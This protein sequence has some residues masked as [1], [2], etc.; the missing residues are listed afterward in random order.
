MA[1]ASKQQRVEV[2]VRLRPTNGQLQTV[3]TDQHHA[4][5]QIQ[6]QQN[7]TR[8]SNSSNNANQER[9]FNFDGVLDTT[10]S[11]QDVLDL[12][13]LNAV[14]T[15]ID[16]VNSTIFAYGQT[17]SGKT[18][19]ITG[20]TRSFEDRGLCA[21][22][23]AKLFRHA[24][25]SRLDGTGAVTIRVSYVEIYNE[26]V[27]DLLEGGAIAFGG[28]LSQQ[29]QPMSIGTDA[30]AT[31]K[32]GLQIQEKKNGETSLR[33]VRKSLVCSE[34][35]ALNVLFDGETNR[36]IAEHS[37]NQASTRSHCVLTIYIHTSYDAPDVD[38]T[39][40]TSAKLHLVDLAGSE[41]MHKTQSTG[42]TM[43]E[44]LYVNRSLSYLEQVVVALGDKTREHIPYRQSK[45]T[46]ML[47]DSLGGNCK[48][49]MIAC[50]WP[51]AEHDDQTTATLSFAKRMRRVKNAPRVN[52]AK[53]KS[54]L[55][56]KYKSEIKQLRA[57]LA[58]HD[59]MA[60]R[61]GIVYVPLTD[62]QKEE[63]RESVVRFVRDPETNSIPVVSV[64]QVNAVFH[65]FRSML[66]DGG[67]VSPRP[68]T[69]PAGGSSNSGK[70]FATA[71]KP[72]R[73]AAAW[74]SNN[75]TSTHSTAPTAPS[76]VDSK[77]NSK[78][79][80]V[81]FDEFKSGEGAEVNELLV[82]AK[83]DVKAKKKQVKR[84][85][86][87]V[88]E[89]KLQ[90]DL[91]LE[92]SR[93]VTEN[94]DKQQ[95]LQLLKQEKKQYRNRYD[96]LQEAQSELKAAQVIKDRCFKQLVC[97]FERSQRVSVDEKLPVA[98]DEKRVLSPGCPRN[99]KDGRSPTKSQ[100]SNDSCGCRSSTRSIEEDTGSNVS[101]RA[102]PLS[103]EQAFISA[104]SSALSRKSSHK[105]RSGTS[106]RK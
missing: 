94:N 98:A 78:Y 71:A 58:M 80:S 61:E 72:P 100:P 45:L 101:R 23:F 53:D 105:R 52:V 51:V 30:G 104:S 39:S 16:G 93:D 25:K 38:A 20:S 36:A 2:F 89:H 91:L 79:E 9:V 41:R 65:A 67:V 77:A 90:I 50:I 40:G 22:V 37:L 42:T 95:Q 31:D 46:H 35:E 17:G 103:S 8:N 82:Q 62:E 56:I 43:K 102:E 24:N 83:A 26:V 81:S 12:C 63:V 66:L 32:Q 86:T 70:P 92:Q 106:R 11:Q 73:P 44:A 13:G 69:L 49:Y 60:G 5:V 99:V 18:H 68:S 75:K 7:S 6:Q 14:Q 74:F 1:Q 48:T 33:G 64:R 76:R 3:E 28:L 59:A 84:L 97:D 85:A 54:E 21:R 87:S 27:Y 10:A 29:V 88:N 15:V 34:E 47:K 19:T 55:C 57:E 4:T 96:E